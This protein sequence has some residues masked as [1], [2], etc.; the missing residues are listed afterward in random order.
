MVNRKR[1]LRRAV[2]FPV[3]FWHRSNVEKSFIG[4]TLNVSAGGLFI[5]T[6]H[7]LRPR[8]PIELEIEE[9]ERILRI[10]AQVS[11]AAIFPPLY[12]QVF[13]SGMGIRFR[14]PEEPAARHIAQLGVV[15][16]DRGGRREHRRAV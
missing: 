3:R 15:L 4:F 11:H 8:A 16:T 6:R 7:P 9:P 12:Q 13:K 10:S 5:A 14:R 1:Q 2:R